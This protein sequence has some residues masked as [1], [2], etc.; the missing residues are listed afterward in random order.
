M[1]AFK[2]IVGLVVAV[3]ILFF[4]VALFLPNES[5]V[6]RSIEINAPAGK[7]FSVVGDLREFEKWDPWTALDPNMSVEYSGS[8]YGVGSTRSWSGN[9]KVGVGTMTF[10]EFTPNEQAVMALDFGEMGGGTAIYD[11][12]E[13][14]GKTTISWSFDT[15]HQNIV[16][17]YFG[18][19]MDS[20]LGKEYEKGLASLKGYVEAL[21]DIKTEEL[22][23]SVDGTQLTGFLAYPLGLLDPVP[24]VLVVHEWWGHNDYARKRAKMLA[25]EGY[26][27]FALDMYGDGKLASHPDDAT[28]FMREVGANTPKAVER[29]DAATEVLKNHQFTDETRIA[30][31]GYC[32]GGS[33]V[34]NMARTGKNLKGVVSFHG[35]LGNLLPIVD[36]AFTPMLVLNG[37]DDPLVP[38]EQKNAFK[39]EVGRSALKVEFIEY[40]GALHA[41]TNPAAD[42]YGEKF[43][44]PLKYDAA[45]DEDSWKRSN[46][47]L[48]HVLY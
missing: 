21:P 43:G 15:T 12:I 33:V 25:R 2:I 27:A 46:E 19:M 30:A 26:V 17:R 3:P 40:P 4:V 10:V 41:F 22:P 35:G 34:L 8:Q 1:K 44:L 14:N 47:F 36:H 18:L 16:H 9:K 39:E 7:V 42:D 6:V 20:M 28:Q 24:G 11:L 23:Y 13:E 5:H 32:F 45:A 31:I 29:F 37:A 48:K 38:A